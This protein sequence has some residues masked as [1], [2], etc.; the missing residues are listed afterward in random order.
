MAM[1]ILSNV[2]SRAGSPGDL[3]TYLT[4]EVRG[5]TG[6]RCVLLIECLSTP[7]AV[8]HRVV[9]VNPAR[10]REWAESLTGTRLYEVAHSVPAAQLWREEE[11]S[12]LAGLLGREGFELSMVLPL[13]AGAFRVGAMLVLGLP[14][15]EHVTSVLGVLDNLSTVVALV[16]RN[17][18]LY[19]RQELLILARTVELRDKNEKLAME[20]V[21]RK[22]AEA[23]LREQHSTLRDI[24]DGVP[25]LIFSVDRQHRYTSFNG[26]HAAV[27]KALYGAEI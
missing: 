4:E 24:I 20:L 22:R 8:A 21:E 7:A 14:D 23:A 27:M 5:L 9:S 10:R 15:E 12:E 13:S 18:M 3:A 1:D 2:L 6:A 17:A 19:E 11:P 16:L 25:A 26:G